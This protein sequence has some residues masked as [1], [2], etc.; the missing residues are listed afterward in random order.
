VPQALPHV[1]GGPLRALA[2]TTPARSPAIPEVPTVA[3]A[4]VSGFNV[5]IWY[6]ILATGRTPKPIIDKLNGE[7]VKALQSADARQ[8]LMSL[9]LEPVGNGPGQ[10]GA[11]IRA[12]MAQWAR[13]V[14]QAGIKVE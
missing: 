11:T 7:I 1:Q 10:F 8:Q 2:V 6:G 4:G 12:E 3:E 9:G 13:V 14:K 5:T